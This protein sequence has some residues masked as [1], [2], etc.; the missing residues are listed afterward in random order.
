MFSSSIRRFST[1]SVSKISVSC[2]K[3]KST[4]KYTEL[5]KQLKET[6]KQI[7]HVQHT[8]SDTQWIGSCSLIIASVNTFLSIATISGIY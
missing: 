4:E 5:L 3:C 1:S 6:D 7:L 8:I 2:S